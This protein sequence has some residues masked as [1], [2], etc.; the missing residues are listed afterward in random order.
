M[1]KNEGCLGEGSYGIVYKVKCLKS[2]ILSGDRWV[3]L[4]TSSVK[5][6]RKM[7]FSA[8]NK[9]KSSTGTGND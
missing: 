6:R 7:N 8:I 4:D 2:S 5:L 9:S 3:A 1:F